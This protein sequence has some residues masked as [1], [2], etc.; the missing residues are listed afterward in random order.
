MSAS[1]KYDLTSSS[2]DRPLYGSAQRG[3]Y[4]ASN[5]E[6]PILS[7]LPN[8]TR[9]SSGAT[10]GDVVKFFQCLRIDPKAMAL[11]RWGL[12]AIY[13]NMG[14]FEVEQQKS[15]EKAKT[16]IPSKRTRTSMT[17]VRPNT[18]RPSGNLDRNRDLLRL[19]NSNT[20]QG[21]DRSPTSIAI[22]G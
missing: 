22:E 13:S 7:S 17:D 10:Q 18:P 21:E 1:N 2:P 8:M 16:A 12:K 3:S 15:D 20:V 11:V 5:M 9:S 4:G 14:G 19:P 6:N